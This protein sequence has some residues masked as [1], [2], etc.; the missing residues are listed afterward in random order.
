MTDKTENA[1]SSSSDDEYPPLT[2]N[3]AK[4]MQVGELREELKKRGINSIGS[5]KKLVNRVKYYCGRGMIQIY[6]KFIVVFN[7]L[8]IS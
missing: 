8:I 3:E 2:F 1:V 5:K 4:K 6:Q 7:G